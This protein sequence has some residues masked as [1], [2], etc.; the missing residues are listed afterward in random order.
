MTHAWFSFSHPQRRLEAGLRRCFASSFLLWTGCT[1][2]N[3]V[4]DDPAGN[5]ASNVY[6]NGPSERSIGLWVDPGENPLSALAEVEASDRDRVLPVDNRVLG[7]LMGEVGAYFSATTIYTP[8]SEALQA[9]TMQCE[10]SI[11]PDAVE[12]LCASITAPRRA[13]ADSPGGPIQLVLVNELEHV[14][15]Q[16]SLMRKLLGCAWDAGFRYLG[17]E[18]LEED[19][20]A[21]EARG[22]VSRSESGEFTREPQ[23]ARLLEDGMGLGYDIVSF[24]V[25]DPCTDCRHVQAITL[26][27]EEQA[28]NLVAKTFAID[29]AAKVLVLTTARQAYKR[30]WGST[31]PYITSLGAHL[32]DQ[33]G[34]EPY[35]VEQVAV[36]RPSLQFGASPPNPPSGMYV[37][38]GEVNG[39]CMGS[40]GP[41]SPTG[42]GTLDAAVIHVPPQSDAQRWDWLHAA[43]DERRSVTPNC[44]SCTPGERLL[45]QAFPAGIDRADRVPVD[46]AL[47][48]AGEACQL[49][50]PAAT[51]DIVVW[52]ETGAVGISQADLQASDAATIAPQ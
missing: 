20:A 16:R 51:Y 34:I 2:S 8:F 31:Q 30:I 11:L 17:V 35:S 49:V 18:A 44:A 27:A 12:T 5:V 29:A 41:G 45:M 50:L 24:E 14:A 4:N 52:S 15:Y 3:A 40:Y 33:T 25:A 7:E 46:Q 37:A 19:D 26:H 23:M 1:V 38:S 9:Q 32:W 13:D 42:M 39:R 6:M 47:C 28:T 22:H 48:A 21:L 43:A 10:D 36:D